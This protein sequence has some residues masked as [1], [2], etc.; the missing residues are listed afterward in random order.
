MTSIET[1]EQLGWNYA[2]GAP[3]AQIIEL[4]H[5]AFIVHAKNVVMLGPSGVGKST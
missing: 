1:L 4:D 3:K 2:G 5:L